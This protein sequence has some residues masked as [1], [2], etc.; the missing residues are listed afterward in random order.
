MSSSGNPLQ[1]QSDT[2]RIPP[3]S[4][5]TDRGYPVDYLGQKLI[6]CF[7]H[8]VRNPV[9][10]DGEIQVSKRPG[11]AVTDL[12]FS[13]HLSNYA[14]NSGD[15]Y[16]TIAIT[17]LY[18]V[19]VIAVKDGN[20]IRIIQVRPESNT[21]VL[22]GT[23][24]TSTSTNTHKVYFSYVWTGVQP[25]P[26]WTL[27]VNYV[28]GDG[29]T[30]KA[31]HAYAAGGVFTAGSLTQITVATS[32]WGS[33]VQTRGPI[34]QLNNQWYVAALDGRIYNTGTALPG[35]SYI[36]NTDTKTSPAQGWNNTGNWVGSRFPEQFEGMILYKHH[37]V[38]FGKT[39]I[40][41]F[42]DEGQSISG[43]GGG[44]PL[45]PTDQALIRF[46][47]MACN[48]MIN[49]DDVLYWIAYGK[50]DTVGVW[51]LDGYTPVKISNKSIDDHIVDLFTIGLANESYLAS[52]LM[53][54][55]KHILIAGIPSYSLAYLFDQT[56]WSA[57]LRNAYNSQYAIGSSLCYVVDDKTWWNL[58]LNNLN[59]IGIL[60]FTLFNR[61]N[62]SAYRQYFIRAD[63]TRVWYIER[64]FSDIDTRDH[65]T[66]TT[67]LAIVQLNTLDFSNEKRKRLNKIKVIFQGNPA[68]SNNNT[69]YL[70][71]GYEKDN[72]VSNVSISNR[73]LDYYQP[74]YRYYWNNL[75]M[76]RVLNLVLVDISNKPMELRYLELDL[77]QGIN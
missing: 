35:S 5:E 55:K 28:D 70:I 21:S 48:H 30:N 64:T 44:S 7:A 19:Y 54:G 39:S 18:D 60:P 61:T 13:T 1:Q 24:A 3:Y 43:T 12:D 67:P 65:V 75:G 16:A 68:I 76:A 6:N 31:Y 71:L 46:G 51:K 2:V 41:F 32:P 23:I 25:S 63:S 33:G 52:F 59:L 15:M 38:A 62:S 69:S 22:I 73:P 4:M 14:G 17:N 40:Q 29:V 47:V 42:N 34:L 74:T 77:N 26:V 56:E 58:S 36:S 9:T 10:G 27:T 11:L 20:N 37:L 72:N 49:V 66:E 8:V 45:L 50:N 53:G 57:S